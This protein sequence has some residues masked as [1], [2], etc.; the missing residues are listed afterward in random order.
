MYGPFVSIIDE[1]GDILRKGE[2][3]NSLNALK[4]LDNK[5][6]NCKDSI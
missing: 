4:V 5:L 3:L 6:A 2:F 1:L